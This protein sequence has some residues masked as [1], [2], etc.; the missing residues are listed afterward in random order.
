MA[1]E[2]GSANDP[3]DLLDKWKTFLT[4]TTGLYTHLETYAG[5]DYTRSTFTRGGKYFNVYAKTSGTKDSLI[6]SLSTGH[7]SGVDAYNQTNESSR[8][9]TNLISFPY[10]SYEFFSYSNSAYAVVQYAGGKYRHFGIGEL[11]KCGTYQGGEFVVGTYWNQLSN[12]INVP[13]SAHHSF[14]F[15]PHNSTPWSD[16]LS[17]IRADVTGAPLPPTWRYFGSTPNATMARGTNA[18]AIMGGENYGLVRDNVT[19][20][21]GRSVLLPIYCFVYDGTAKY[22]PL[23]YVEN[24]RTLSLENHAS[25]DTL[26]I[27]G[28]DWR[29]FPIVQ[30]NGASGQENSGYLG[31]AYKKVA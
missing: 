1:W 8:C 9:L 23:G 16:T 3:A 27:A 17:V 6:M 30:R 31:M 22:H 13:F 25:G 19:G 5:T 15:S 11:E 29:I 10:S 12:N 14:P 26:S 24:V 20:T 18:G 21:T 2:S 4:T 7:V 28:D